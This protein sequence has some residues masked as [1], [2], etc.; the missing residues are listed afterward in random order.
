LVGDLELF[1]VETIEVSD[2]DRWHAGMLL[3]LVCLYIIVDAPGKVNVRTG[4]QAREK[5]ETALEPV[6]IQPILGVPDD[7]YL[8]QVSTSSCET[9]QT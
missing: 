9:L 6:V 8:S 1:D 7:G 5:K 2:I 3:G 4:Q